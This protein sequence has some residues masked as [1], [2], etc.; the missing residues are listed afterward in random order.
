MTPA[1]RTM[2]TWALLFPSTPRSFPF[3][4]GIRTLLRAL[5]I[6]TTGIL[7]GGHV[8]D[9]PS[10]ILMPW[11]WGSIVSGL[12]LFATDIYAS[13]AI[14]FE[15]RGIAVFT[16]L[17]L[18]LLIPFMW[19]SRVALLVAVLVIGAVSSHLPRTYRHRV[20]F[21]EDKIVVD[22]RRG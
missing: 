11:L 14:L 3:R 16:K 18:M 2:K 19:E 1:S 13:C 8:F 5:H 9:Q 6:L 22:Q 20:L 17:L 15:A 7:L 10:E 12:L 4:R 21:F